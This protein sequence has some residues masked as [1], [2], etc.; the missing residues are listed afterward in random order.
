M[1][2]TED[3]RKQLD[4]ILRSS[5]YRVYDV[6]RINPLTKLWNDFKEWLYEKVV[7]LFPSAATNEKMAKVMITSILLL[8]G[9]LLVICIFLLIRYVKRKQQF[10]DHIPFVEGKEKDWTFATHISEAQKQE[11]AG[12]F[13]QAS[14]HL[15]LALLLYSHKQGWLEKGLWKTNG[16]Y[17]LELRTVNKNLADEFYQLARIFD[18]ITYGERPINKEEYKAYEKR[19]LPLLNVGGNKEVE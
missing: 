18:E 10:R 6:Q 5:E 7:E 9:V 15:F 8:V 3:A 14:R 1:F 11:T 17:Y 16:E 19:I 2:D 13:S 12:D 4:E